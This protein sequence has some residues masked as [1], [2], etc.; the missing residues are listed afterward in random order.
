MNSDLQINVRDPIW[1]CINLLLMGH[2]TNTR[3]AL[4]MALKLFLRWGG[5]LEGDVVKESASE[6]IKSIT[7]KEAKNYYVYLINRSGFTS[8]TQEESLPTINLNIEQEARLAS[9]SIKSYLSRLSAIFSELYLEGLVVGNPWPGLV[10]KVKSDNNRK[11]FYKSLDEDVIK[12]TFKELQKSSFKN[13]R[14]RVIFLMCTNGG[15]RVSE[16]IKI[17]I[18]DLLWDDSNYCTIV[19]RNTKSGKTQKQVLP[20]KASDILRAWVSELK[21][22]GSGDEGF[23]IPCIRKNK[24]I[25]NDAFSASGVRYIIKGIFAKE[26]VVVRPHDLRKTYADL[27]GAKGV[28]VRSIK[29]LMRHSSVLTT[30]RYLDN[31]SYDIKD[32]DNVFNPLI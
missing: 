9:N 19:L 26:G 17:R 7:I 24:K 28:D 6:F 30:E 2:K 27:L 15:F 31:T 29:E 1:D 18:K 11:W 23:L 25:S 32:V 4:R 13:R 3:I 14:N 16:L 21:R 22:K 20:L 8:T 10:K 12:K 5:Q